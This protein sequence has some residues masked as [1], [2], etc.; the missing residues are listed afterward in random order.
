MPEKPRAG[1]HYAVPAELIE[2]LVRF[3][4]VDRVR[5][6]TSAFGPK[7]IEQAE[8]S[9][10]VRAVDGD[11]VDLALTGATRTMSRGQWPVRGFLDTDN[12]GEQE[13]GFETELSG[14]ATFDM[15]SG[16][17]VAF[18]LIASGTRW[19]GTP[20]NSRGLDLEPTPIGVVLRLAP[21]DA[22][23]VAPAHVWLYGWQ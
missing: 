14:E 13:M 4:L 12:P 17:F 5:G 9:V 21:K 1:A 22:P 8:L 23:H 18:E 10:E 2:R 16:R 19:G 7:S 3:H 15:A 20:F 6:L 11:R